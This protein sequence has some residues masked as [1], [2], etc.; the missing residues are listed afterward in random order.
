MKSIFY[1]LIFFFG[2]SSV[3]GQRLKP[4]SSNVIDQKVH[5]TSGL[6]FW[7]DK[8]WTHNDDGDTNLYALDKNSCEILET[9]ALK[10]VINKD[11]ESISQ[12]ENYIYIGDFG[13]NV[14]GNRTDLH[15]L[16]IEKESLLQG[17]QKIDSIQFNYSDQNDFTAKK[18]NETDFDGEAF[19]VSKDS[20]Y[21]FS[22]QWKSRKTSVYSLPKNPGNHIANLKSTYNVNGLITDA[23][24]IEGTNQVVLCGYSKK[25][26]PFLY[27]LSDYN[28]TDFFSG[29]KKKIKLKLPFHQI[30]GITSDGE[31]IYFTNEQFVRKPFINATQKLHEINLEEII[32]R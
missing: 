6:L 10:K 2:C 12:D 31:K 23:T 26:K 13:N 19:I 18:S 20:I 22:K 9:I 24:F 30:E 25:L 5:E 29:N 21:I 7:N 17:I 32:N 28:L 27:V 11:W 1:L 15:L 8:L 16:R 14:T 4:T 3:L